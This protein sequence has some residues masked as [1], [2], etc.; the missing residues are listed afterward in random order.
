MLAAGR[1]EA[2]ETGYGSG[3]YGEGGYGG[4]EDGDDDT[5]I[6]TAPSVVTDPV[7]DVTD[8]SAMMKGTVTD[9]GDAK[10]VDLYFEYRMAGSSAWSTTASQRLTNEGYCTAKLENLD[11]ETGY[12]YRVVAESDVGTARGEVRSF[13]TDATETAEPAIKRLDLADTSGPNPHVDL[14][15][16]WCVTYEDGALAEVRLIVRNDNDRLLDGA[17]ISVDG[18]SAAGSET[19]KIK[20]GAGESYVVTL[21]VSDQAGNVTREEITL[22]T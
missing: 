22:I 5:T 19:F 3:G 4:V 10:A 8:S 15:V 21:S 6:P 20:H 17:T 14:G 16:D 1:A 9:M 7:T 11:A 18:S 12:E 13:T 2:S